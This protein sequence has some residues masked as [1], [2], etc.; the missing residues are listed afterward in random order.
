M[1]MFKLSELTNGRPLT[2]V[3]FVIFQK[4]DI[5]RHFQISQK[6]FLN[7]MMTIEDHYSKS[8]PFHNSMHAADV[9]QSTHVL[10]NMPALDTVFT[11]LE[12][13]AAILAATIHD[14]DHPG[15]TNQYLIN[16]SSELALM[17]NDESV[18]E[19]H[20]LAVAFKLLQNQ[21]CNVLFNFNKKQR[22]TLRKMIIDMVLSTDMSKHMSLLANLKTMVETKKVAGSGIILLDNYTDRIQV[23]ENLVHCAD[24]SNPTKPLALYRRWVDLLM[25]EFFKQGD[26]EREENMDVSPM[27]DRL[28]ATMEKTQVRFSDL[29]KKFCNRM[30][31]NV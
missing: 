20:H 8:N 24:L 16:S 9:T 27:C 6:L 17:Y 19:N 15:L 11:N 23:L 14:V 13:L 28:S 18:L 21:D 4:R 10:L 3:S 26:K 22:Q 5:F 29:K 12:I 30:Y 31:I 1:D 7:Y 2:C 25:E